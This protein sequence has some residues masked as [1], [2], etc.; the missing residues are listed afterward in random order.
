MCPVGPVDPLKA[1]ESIYRCSNQRS[2]KAFTTAVDQWHH[3]RSTTQE[4]ESSSRSTDRKWDHPRSFDW[5]EVSFVFV[6]LMLCRV[7][8]LENRLKWEVAECTIG[9]NSGGVCCSSLRNSNCSAHRSYPNTPHGTEH[10][11]TNG[12]SSLQTSSLLFSCFLLHLPALAP[13][14]A[15]RGRDWARGYRG[16][17]H[18]RPVPRPR[19]C[20]WTPVGWPF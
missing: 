12:A 2:S 6:M 7:L 8:W 11:P 15:G 5:Q 18:P 16:P 17:A 10:S 14:L 3:F 20:M 19:A 1:S 13:P 9:W 4:A